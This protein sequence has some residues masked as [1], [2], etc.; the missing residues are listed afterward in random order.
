MPDTLK[1]TNFS[2]NDFYFTYLESLI[3][4]ERYTSHKPKIA[5]KISVLQYIEQFL[6]FYPT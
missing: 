2:Q 4:F 3:G 1:K 6:T 5:P